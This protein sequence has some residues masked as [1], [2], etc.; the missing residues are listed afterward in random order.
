[1]ARL[2][3]RAGKCVI[4][5]TTSFT[6]A[7]STRASGIFGSYHPEQHYMRGPGPRCRRKYLDV[8]VTHAIEKMRIAHE[9]RHT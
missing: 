4:R 7:C 5:L 2:L 3:V 1:M 9:T 6:E 8:P